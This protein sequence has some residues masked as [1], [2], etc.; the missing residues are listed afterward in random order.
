MNVIKMSI[1]CNA[2]CVVGR[3]LWAIGIA[4]P[5]KPVTLAIH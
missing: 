3:V 5:V 2:W 4:R 1:A